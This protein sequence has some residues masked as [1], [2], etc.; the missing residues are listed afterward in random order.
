MQKA[1]TICYGLCLTSCEGALC[2]EANVGTGSKEGTP[3]IS[4]EY[5][6][7]APFALFQ[8]SRKSR[9]HPGGYGK[10]CNFQNLLK[11]F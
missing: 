4:L 5:R 9:M 11:I 6:V 1:L 10:F 2:S 7:L 8:S 3:V